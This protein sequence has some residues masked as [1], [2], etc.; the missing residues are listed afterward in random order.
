MIKLPHLYDYQEKL[1][2]DTR[3][4]LTVKRAVIACM[5]QGAG[6]TR[7]TKNILGSVVNRGRRNDQSG[8]VLFV[9]H[10][11]G[12]VQNASNSFSEN[13]SLEHG[14]LMSGCE[15]T[16]GLPVQVGSIDTMLSWY[17]EGGKYDSTQT[18]D[19]IVFD[20]CHAHHSK[21]Q[22]FLTAHNAKRKELGLSEPYVLGLSATP[23]AQGLSDI[24]KTIVMGPTTAWMIENGYLKRF[25]YFQ[26]KEGQLE[27]LVRRGDE[28]TKDS[29]GEAMEGLAGDLV[30]DLKR[31]AEG[32]AT[33]GFFHRL[34]QAQEAVE[35]LRAAGIRPE[36]VDG[37]T[38][39]DERNQIFRELNDGTIDYIANVGVIERGTD[40][41]RIGC[42]QLCTAIGSLPRYLQMIGRGSRKHPGVEDCVI[43]DHGGN[44]KRLG[45]FDD[46]VNWTLDWSS[47]PSK[48][49]KTRPSISCP[50]CSVVYRGGRCNACGYEPMKPERKSQGLVFLGGEL[51]EVKKSSK[52]KKKKTMEAILVSSLY[53]AGRSN[54]TFPQAIAIAQTEAAAQGDRFVVPKTFTVA[55]RTYRT[56]PFGHPDSSRRVRATYGFTV[57]NNSPDAN[58][59]LVQ[60]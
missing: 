46:P 39:D 13:P 20:E 6:K 51:Q 43:L 60:A 19:F 15:T 12:L 41:P 24:Y 45:F 16:G 5:S 49:H 48:E 47:R 54:K 29:V 26:G 35:I 27:K 32:R 31:F 44:V 58:P 40:I 21:F 36:Y 52:P 17:C 56:I 1:R 42:I 28:F 53:R 4:A 33:V 7:V 59:Y 3:N 57:R 55:G 9:V 14:V 23:Q 2:S 8:H 11:R 22:T 25:R 50:K 37:R 38:S 30:I 10:R 18:Y 34:S